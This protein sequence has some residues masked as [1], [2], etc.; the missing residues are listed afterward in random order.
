MAVRK[1]IECDLC[2]DLIDEDSLKRNVW[3]RAYIAK[4]AGGDVLGTSETPADICEDCSR[5][6]GQ[7][8]KDQRCRP[9]SKG[10]ANG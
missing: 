8:I 7:W 6:L 1:I 5:S 2:D 3:C 4:R 9:Q 10:T